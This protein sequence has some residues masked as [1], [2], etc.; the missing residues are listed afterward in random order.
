MKL[1]ALTAVVTLAI[2]F[3]PIATS[4]VPITPYANRVSRRNTLSN[5]RSTLQP[6]F[7][8]KEP[9]EEPTSFSTPASLITPTDSDS[10]SIAAR[11]CTKIMANKVVKRTTFL[12]LA[13]L[14]VYF[15]NRV[16]IFRCRLYHFLQPA[17]RAS[18]PLPVLSTA[19]EFL[20]PGPF[21]KS[22]ILALL[23]TAVRVG[24]PCY[25]VVGAI[26]TLVS[27]FFGPS[28]DWKDADKPEIRR[29][30]DTY[31]TIFEEPSEPAKK[32]LLDRLFDKKKPSPEAAGPMEYLKIKNLNEVYASYD[33]SLLA[34][35]VNR[36]TALIG[37]RN[38]TTMRGLDL[39]A[40]PPQILEECVYAEATFLEEAKGVKEEIRKAREKVGEKIGQEVGEDMGNSAE[41]KKAKSNSELQ[42]AVDNF[43][44]G[45]G[46]NMEKGTDEIM[47]EVM[48]KETELMVLEN[49]FLKEISC[50]VASD[51][52]LMSEVFAKNLVERIVSVSGTGGVLRML[53]KRPLTVL[54]GGAPAPGPKTVFVLDFIGDEHASQVDFLREEVTAIT[55][56]GSA[57]DEV[58]L[59]L[60][61]GGGTVTGYGLA[62]AQLQRIKNAGMKLTVCIEE[63]AASGG[64]MMACLGDTIVASPFAVLGSIGVLASAPN[65]YERLKKE[66][67][68][69]RDI[70]AGKYKRTMTPW[71][72]L[73]EED[74]AKTKEEIGEVFDLFKSFVKKNRPILDIDAVATGETWYGEDAVSRGLCDSLMTIDEV[75][76]ARI[77]GGA[78]VFSVAFDPP[79]EEPET[80]ANL[81]PGA[82]AGYF[83]KILRAV[84]K[85]GALGAGAIESNV[86]QRFLLK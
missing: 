19:R 81:L 70:T 65:F 23:T 79:N 43:L 20:T 22:L 36:P 24:L 3:A 1:L 7:S 42:A 82:V 37:Y 32:S 76:Q 62:T 77:G 14:S 25:I 52:T 6:L 57:G 85:E 10:T 38:A 35:T 49:K 61:T 69:Y 11:V 26:K 48:L 67:V 71:K 45:K 68:E 53:E 30:Y 75:V 18:N 21:G 86:Q 34:S 47:V 29:P 17:V 73:D 15:L 44:A 55:R 12:L 13:S 60:Q 63:V 39:P 31:Q 33:Y 83:A 51:K 58:I 80:L 46:F 9:N 66:G 40:L 8:N 59:N 27:P 16:G 74:V 72:K 5:T 78:N 56:A 50:I 54:L 2:S 84:V 64:Y 41:A 4:F 28:A